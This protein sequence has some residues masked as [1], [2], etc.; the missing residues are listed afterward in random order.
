MGEEEVVADTVKVAAEAPACTKTETGTVKAEDKL[1]ESVTVI[2]PAGAAMERVTVQLVDEGATR[3]V[4]AH[5]KEE[6]AGVLVVE[7]VMET[8]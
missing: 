1:L 5:G 3:L 6:M 2:P 7:T 8:D 4:L